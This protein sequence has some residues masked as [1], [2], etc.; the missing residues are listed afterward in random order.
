MRVLGEHHKG[1]KHDNLRVAARG[2]AFPQAMVWEH[3][4]AIVER[5]RSM[6]ENADAFIAALGVDPKR[7]ADQP[8]AA[9]AR[10]QAIFWYQRKTPFEMAAHWETKVSLCPY[11]AE[12][13][14]NL[15]P[16]DQR[17]DFRRALPIR[18]WSMLEF[19]ATR[20]VEVDAPMIMPAG[21]PKKRSNTRLGR[22][23]LHALSASTIEALAK[24]A[25]EH[26]E[27]LN[28]GAGKEIIAS[29]KERAKAL[30]QQDIQVV[31]GADARPAPG[32][33]GKTVLWNGTFFDQLADLAA[34]TFANLSDRASLCAASAQRLYDIATA[35]GA[36]FDPEH[37]RARLNAAGY[38]DWKREPRMDAN[39]YPQVEFLMGR[40]IKNGKRRGEVAST[41]QGFLRR[42]LA[43]LKKEGRITQDAPDYCIIE[44]IGDPPRNTDQKAEILEAQKK[45]RDDRDKRF[46]EHDLKD[47]GIASKRRRITLHAQQGGKCPYTGED[48]GLDP[49]HADLEIE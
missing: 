45:R 8:S 19:A 41:V 14:L 24:L 32:T 11:T 9:A 3:L 46:A 39:P 15:P 26:Q 20:R 23:L 49:L 29:F 10:E 31:Y 13:K 2:Y 33:K 7:C 43:R 18:Q 21:A 40:R 34:P 4:L 38:Y 17:C 47:E 16:H 48:L 12:K 42:L 27:R 35:D 44:V 6:I 1:E 37:A 25:V 30:V 5:H 36:S 28:A 22:K